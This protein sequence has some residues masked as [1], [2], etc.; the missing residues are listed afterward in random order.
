M[1]FIEAYLRPG[2]EVLDIGAN[3]GVYS[4]FMATLVGAEGS[5]VAFEPVEASRERLRLQLELNAISNVRIEPKAVSDRSG[6]VRFGA[7]GSTAT[8]RI[9]AESVHKTTI[10]V[11]SISLDDWTGWRS[12]AFIKMD[13]E[14]AEPLALLGARSRLAVQP[15]P[16]ILLELAGYS[17][18]F[19]FTSDA[20]LDLLSQ[21]GYGS[22]AFEPTERRLIEAPEPWRLGITN[23]LAV[24][25]EH[26]LAV[27]ERLRAHVPIQP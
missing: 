25:A 18:S 1:K 19:G 22:F 4:V 10:E 11:D 8:R 23:V 24:H 16:V 15:P 12:P 5:V 21:Y 7:A 13:I 3:I 27:E 9:E 14:G 26:R 6:T 20:V 2:D 17:Q